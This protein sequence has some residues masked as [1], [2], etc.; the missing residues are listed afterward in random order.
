MMAVLSRGIG[1]AAQGMVEGMKTAAALNASDQEYA[2][3]QRQIGALDRAEALR[4]RMAKIDP[5][6]YQRTTQ[7]GTSYYDQGAFMAEQAK[8]YGEFGETTKA[9][10]LLGGIEEWNRK[11][12]GQ[13]AARIYAARQAGDVPSMLQATS[14]ML[15]RFPNG[16]FAR[17]EDLKYDPKTNTI[18]GIAR[19]MATGRPV[20][21]KPFSINID[22]LY[23]TSLFERDADKAAQ[24]EWAER[25]RRE[26][27]AAIVG[28][29]QPEPQLVGS[30][31]TGKIPIYRAGMQHYAPGPKGQLV[32]YEGDMSQIRWLKAGGG[33][34]VDP[35]EA[36]LLKAVEKDPIEFGPSL[37][38][39]R[40]KKA[41]STQLETLRAEFEQ[42]ARG[43]YRVAVNNVVRQVTSQ[44]RDPATQRN[45]LAQL[46][47]SPEVIRAS[48]TGGYAPQASPLQR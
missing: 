8:A 18:T 33:N 46:G 48:Q 36:A 31:A 34:A 17:P 45:I 1:D 11:E 10:E 4:Q 3:R 6:A 43:D 26:D 37:E 2:L 25:M 21:N 41:Q 13:H 40:A 29:R 44:V 12:R 35:D 7:A 32:P 30:D 23:K 39:Y 22:K 16:N 20:G 28:S 47:I 42:E 27:R 5:T 15:E 19:D 24:L 38:A 9:G 14:E